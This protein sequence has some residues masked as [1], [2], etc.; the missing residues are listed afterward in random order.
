MVLFLMMN[1]LCF[2]IWVFVNGIELLGVSVM[3][4]ICML[5][6]RLVG[7]IKCVVV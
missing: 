4:V 7:L 1:S 3:M 5:W 2:M 6:C